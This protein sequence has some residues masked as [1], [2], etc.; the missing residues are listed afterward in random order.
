MSTC[1]EKTGGGLVTWRLLQPVVKL[2]VQYSSL[3]LVEPGG[4]NA[5]SKAR[6]RSLIRVPL[7][8][9]TLNVIAASDD[10]PATT[11]KDGLKLSPSLP[12][13]VIGTT[14]IDAPFA[15]IQSFAGQSAVHAAP[16]EAHR[17]PRWT[18]SPRDP[19]TPA[20]PN[21]SSSFPS[22]HSRQA[23]QSS[24]SPQGSDD[25][26]A[27]KSRNS[28]HLALKPNTLNSVQ[29]R[30]LPVSLSHSRSSIQ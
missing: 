2:V 26:S 13:V 4:V 15:A 16:F 18:R 24:N 14:L 6:S 23:K 1:C 8:P 22:W 25:R 28:P 11:L 21:C 19:P 5:P 3:T 27:P 17:P 29:N 7:S 9:A 30:V 12:A 20:T 10:W